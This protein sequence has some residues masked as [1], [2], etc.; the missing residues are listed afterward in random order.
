M[1]E[2][3]SRPVRGTERSGAQGGGGRSKENLDR[4]T[5]QHRVSHSGERVVYSKHSVE[6]WSG[7]E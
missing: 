2:Q 4:Q 7:V 6:S 3:L 5:R 1:E